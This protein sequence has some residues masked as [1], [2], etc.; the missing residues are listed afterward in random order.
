MENLHSSF[1]YFGQWMKSINVSKL[2]TQHSLKKTVP[3]EWYSILLENFNAHF[4]IT[5]KL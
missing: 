2:C 4:S 1:N 5:G 3:K